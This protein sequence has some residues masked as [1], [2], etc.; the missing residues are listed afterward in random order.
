MSTATR[1]PS[2]RSQQPSETRRHPARRTTSTS[3]SGPVRVGGAGGG[4]PRT[5]A[6]TGVRLGDPRRRLRVVAG[7]I[8]FLL[9]LLSF[10]LIQLQ[11]VDSKRYALKADDQLVSHV[12]LP[13]S[14]GTITDR[15]G[16][17]LAED[18]DAKDIV[19]DP[20]L[21]DAP[22]QTA[23][24]L[25]PILHKP[26]ADLYAQL[27]A[28]TGYIVVGK[29]VTPAVG[30]AILK[31]KIPGI[32]V[33]P[34]TRRFYPGG[35]LAAQLLGFA[36]SSGTDIVGRA[37]LEGQLNSL[38]T[39]KAGSLTFEHDPQG[40]QI[41]AGEHREKAAVEG[42]N[43]QLTLNR[44]IQWAAQSAIA[45][46]VAATRAS[47]GFAIVL[48]PRNG[49]IYAMANAPT[50]DANTAAAGNQTSISSALSNPVVGSAYEPGSV[51]KVATIGM[52][53]QKGLVTPT[54]H[55]VVP[56]SIKADGHTV[57]DSEG[58][59]GNYTLAGVLAKSSNLGTVK[60]AQMFNNNQAV[61]DAMNSFG[62]GSPT[63]IGINGESAGYVPAGRTWSA[64][65]QANIPFGQGMSAT[66][67]QIAMMYATIAN[68]GVHVT[69]SLIES[70]QQPG[71]DRKAAKPG[72][73]RRV[74]SAATAKTLSQIL[75]MVVAP[76]GTA[77]KVAIP[78]YRVAGKTGTA[79]R[80]DASGQYTQWT[81]SFV[82][83]APA[84]NPQ[85]LVETVLI[86][87]QNAHLGAEV[88]GPAFDR[89]MEF[90][91]AKLG[92]APTNTAP[93]SYPLVFP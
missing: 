80:I 35:D 76:G 45:A 20:Y 49:Q 25:S 5:P 55:F 15:D 38:L 91:L 33:S 72:P 81:S 2:G 89:I 4:G 11:G 16:V 52:A 78:G 12:P 83:F 22:L 92:I 6:S 47:G 85:L 75:E 65:Q 48:N 79:Q 34:S 8:A 53:L 31:E 39:G 68:G 88:A 44:D 32:T 19:A 18:V 50:F 69:P 3:S 36:S 59:G 27:V 9:L 40:R 46:Q 23:Q 62:L 73:T 82:G 28:R 84:D 30:T 56:D 77:P 17:A 61:S 87:P 42:T 57:R 58:T 21:I 54:T 67:L 63:G 1:P 10:R 41:P 26:V 29:G 64:I 37:G 13:A 66:A 51:A 70:T 60:V 93:V 71:H 43:V 24:M 7:L 74:I 90:A 86:Q 14:R